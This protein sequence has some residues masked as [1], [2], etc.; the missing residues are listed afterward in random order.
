MIAN[1]WLPNGL[2][3]EESRTQANIDCGI[4]S[5]ESQ[6]AMMKVVAVK[7]STTKIAMA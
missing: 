1:A 2:L 6:A 4:E 7:I 5:W 3:M